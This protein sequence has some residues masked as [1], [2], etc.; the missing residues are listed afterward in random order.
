VVYV[1]A[2]S[3]LRPEVLPREKCLV[4]VD[5]KPGRVVDGS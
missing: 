3:H 1:E 2:G 4:A 5:Q